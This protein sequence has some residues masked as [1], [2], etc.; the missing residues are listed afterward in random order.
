M[1]IARSVNEHK[2]WSI[3][4][5]TSLNFLCPFVITGTRRRN[6]KTWDNITD[7]IRHRHSHLH[8]Y[9]LL[10]QL[11]FF[12]IIDSGVL[13]PAKSVVPLRY[14]QATSELWGWLDIVIKFLLLK[15]NHSDTTEK[16]KKPSLTSQSCLLFGVFSSVYMSVMLFTITLIFW[17][18]N[19]TKDN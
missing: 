5:A 18:S 2:V 4:R 9:H 3:G 10:M 1:F 19:Y 8:H 11:L 15:R 13:G 14:F 6:S 7:F 17:L 16:Y 12:T